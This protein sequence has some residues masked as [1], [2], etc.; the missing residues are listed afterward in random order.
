MDLVR[1]T[2]PT[3]KLL[4]TATDGDFFM[5]GD[6]NEVIM[7]LEDPKCVCN[8]KS[9]CYDISLC[10]QKL[11]S[12]AM[13]MNIFFRDNYAKYSD[14]ENQKYSEILNK[15]NEITNTQRYL[16]TKL[17]FIS[18]PTDGIDVPVLNYPHALDKQDKLYKKQNIPNVQ[19]AVYDDQERLLQIQK[20][21]Y[22]ASGILMSFL[23]VSAIAYP[24]LRLNKN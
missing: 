11:K 6:S 2:H 3:H 8:P 20:Q 4:P 12:N 24:V 14:S 16:N 23:L 10:K 5:G 22:L 9:E 7:N 17:D 18:D 13:N 21:F 19:N 1:I 15:Y